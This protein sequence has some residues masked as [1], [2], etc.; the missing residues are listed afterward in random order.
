MAR[1]ARRAARGV[2]GRGCARGGSRNGGARG[3]AGLA[4]WNGGLDPLPGGPSAPGREHPGHAAARYRLPD[5]GQVEPLRRP[6]ASR[7]GRAVDRLRTGA[8]RDGRGARRARP[9]AAQRARPR[10]ARARRGRRIRGARARALAA[11]PRLARP[12]GRA[13]RRVAKMGAGGGVRRRDCVDAGRVPVAVVAARNALLVAVVVMSAR[14]AAPA[15]STGPARRRPPLSRRRSTTDP[16]PRSRTSPAS[17]S[18]S[19]GAPGR[20]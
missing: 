18:G 15:R 5:R 17:A 7:R 3:A 16:R 2:A 14:A 12:A 11:V 19:A 8:R 1:R 20:A 4:R 13:R 6:R 10:A 9:P